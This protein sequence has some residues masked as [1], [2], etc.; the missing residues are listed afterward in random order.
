[1]SALRLVTPKEA[2]DRP[3]RQ[4]GR[5]DRYE[6]WRTNNRW[7]DL[8]A[9]DLQAVLDKAAKGDVADWADLC[10]FA[11]G[12]DDEIVSL[13]GTRRD[14]IVQAD[15]VVAPN[16]HGNPQ[17]AQLA[18]EFCDEQIGRVRNWKRF[19]RDMFHAV[20]VG[21]SANELS[22]RRDGARRLWYTDRIEHRHGHR[23]RYGPQWDLRLYDHGHKPG[24]D[25]YGQTLRPDQWVVHSH[26][27]QAGYPGIGG[28][29]RSTV[30][31]W[32]FRRWCDKFWIQYMER[33]GNPL[34]YAKV[35][36]D[37]PKTVRNNMLEGLEDLANDGAAVIE[38]GGE[39]VVEAAAQAAKGDEAHER[40]MR[41]AAAS[42]GKA[43]LGTSDANE[44]GPNGARAATE[45]RVSAT[46]D[47]RMVAD[48]ENMGATLHEQLFPLWL[49]KNAHLLG[50]PASDIPIPSYT[51]KTAED[52]IKTDAGDLQDEREKEGETSDKPIQVQPE[53]APRLKPP[54]SR[55]MTLGLPGPKAKPRKGRTKKTSQTS[56]PSQS[57]LGRALRGE[58]V[59]PES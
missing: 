32:M 25:S 19:L 17:V 57:P 52:E 58:L 22:W 3:L 1:M 21:Y 12:S 28:V 26:Q 35:S 59:D 43:W 4:Q 8:G 33:H 53:K 54:D 23:F 20:A 30:W 11:I 48:G 16:E 2:D 41:F 27:E 9:Q 24:S 50:V 40:Y 5:I 36:P 46:M 39:L 31:R 15:Y 10:E 56:S 6:R 55:Q 44:S 18:A 49:E 51:F 13:Y 45:T 29:M 14:R 47:P 34:M 7:G 38:E 42:L 37:T